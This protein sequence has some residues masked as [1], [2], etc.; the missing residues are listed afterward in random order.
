MLGMGL[1]AGCAAPVGKPV[2]QT[3]LVET[4]GCLAASCTLSNDRGSWRVERTPGEVALVSSRE[5]L[6]VVCRSD[7]DEQGTDAAPSALSGTHGVGAVAGGIAGGAAVGVALGSVA[8]AFIPALGALVVLSGVAMGAGAGSAIEVSQQTVSYPPVISIAISCKA[9]G[10]AAA[11]QSP[12]R[13]GVGFRGLSLAEAKA[14]GL[15]GRGAV[16]VTEVASGSAARAAGLR[17][18]DVLLMANGQPVA[19]AAQLE[20]LAARLSPGAALA[21]RVWRAGDE[22][23]LVLELP[24]SPP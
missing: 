21:L 15:G 8:L 17:P 9:P 16:L 10:E 2:T 13:F 4:P 6:R 7:D 19:D 5:P 18:D 12:A 14:R 3:I 24:A 20:T 1:L 23:D 11:P 22:F